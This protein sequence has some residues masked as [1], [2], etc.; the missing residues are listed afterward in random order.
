ML[1]IKLVRQLLLC[2]IGH[3]EL[4]I[5]RVCFIQIIQYWALDHTRLWRVYWWGL[6]SISTSTCF[7]FHLHCPK[8]ECIWEFLADDESSKKYFMPKNQAACQLREGQNTKTTYLFTRRCP[9]R[10]ST[11]ELEAN[12]S[13]EAETTF[14]RRY[15]TS[16]ACQME[17]GKLERGAI[18]KICSCRLISLEDHAF[19]WFIAQFLIVNFWLFYELRL[20]PSVCIALSR[21]G[22][23][24]ARVGFRRG[25]SWSRS[26]T[27]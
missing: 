13:W 14:Y 27:P 10:Q 5:F 25:G 2:A 24:S 26:T 11:E 20:G 19:R 21:D 18:G 22:S 8:L 23:S 16:T 4:Q 7:D 15:R 12:S 1:A 6:H 9:S 3:E 17:A